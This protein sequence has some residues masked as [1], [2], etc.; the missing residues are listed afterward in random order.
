M[1]HLRHKENLDVYREIRREVRNMRI[2]TAIFFAVAYILLARDTKYF[3][4]PILFG[5]V[6]LL[7]Q[8]ARFRSPWMS[9]M[10]SLLLNI[11]VVLN[12]GIQRSP[13]MFLFLLPVVSHG[14]ER[15]S[16]WALRVAVINTF[17]LAALEVY[18]AIAEDAFGMAYISSVIVLMYWLSRIIIK[19]QGSLLSYAID[20]EKKA[21]LDP[22]TGLYN[23]R[24]L[25]KYASK[26]IL[27]KI[28]FTLV[29]GDL[30]GF[31]KYNDTHGHQ[32]GDIVLKEFAGILRSSTRST[33][34][35]FRY[36]GDEFVI[37]LP[38]ELDSVDFLYERIRNNLKRS[39]NNIGISFGVSVF[40]K[41]GNSLD[42]ILAV[43]DKSLYEQKRNLNNRV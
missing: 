34:L 8:I 6:F 33:D 7:V 20:M 13:F 22:L 25:E 39:L 28:P 19:T 24:A 11:S 40:P 29:I 38:G 41:D 16:I 17:F 12:T 10:A 21:Y 15:E 30:D 27:N 4:I 32:A 31:K 5:C 9:V 36:G 18:S 3:Y 42:E 35:C 1:Y 23:R 14:I 26:M 43:A 37:V 2:A